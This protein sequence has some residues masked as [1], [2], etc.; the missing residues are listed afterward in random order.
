LSAEIGKSVTVFNQ[1]TDFIEHKTYLERL[2]LTGKASHGYRQN[3]EIAN[4]DSK[5]PKRE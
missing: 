5:T 3:D 1:T 2:G 4:Q